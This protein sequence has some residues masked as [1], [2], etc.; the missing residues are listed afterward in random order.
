[1]MLWLKKL[2]C[3]WRG[4]QFETFEDYTKCARC[5]KVNI[6][7]AQLLKQLIPG[8]NALFGMEYSKYKEAKPD[9][10]NA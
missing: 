9:E 5:G 3:R 6:S 10:K 4:H 2:V 1:M 8:L 7:R